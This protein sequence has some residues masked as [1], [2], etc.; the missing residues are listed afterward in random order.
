LL[1]DTSDAEAR[2]AESHFLRLRDKTQGCNANTDQDL[3]FLGPAAEQRITGVVC[4]FR[5]I[6]ESTLMQ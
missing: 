3:R 5:R 4:I 6:L 1:S 2:G